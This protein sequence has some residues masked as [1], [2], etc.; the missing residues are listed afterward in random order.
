MKSVE[1][2][3]FLKQCASVVPPPPAA[4]GGLSTIVRILEAH[5]SKTVTSTAAKISKVETPVATQYEATWEPVLDY[6]RPIVRLFGAYGK[7]AVTKDLNLLVDAFT[8]KRHL[9]VLS[10]AQAAIPPSSTP[11]KVSAPVRIDVVQKYNR[12]LERALGDDAG[13]SEAIREIED[14]ENVSTSEIIALAKQFALASS[15]SRSAALKKIRA[16]HE[17]LVVGRAKSAATRGRVAG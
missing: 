12:I 8:Q 11:T 7:P 4:S 2:A 16:R 1:L 6:L 3:E 13:F 17:S 5:G 14:P 10:F 15:K 9:A